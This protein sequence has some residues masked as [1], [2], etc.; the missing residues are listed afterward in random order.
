MGTVKCA[1]Q[2][3]RREEERQSIAAARLINDDGLAG[4]GLETQGEEKKLQG[5]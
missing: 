2:K 5:D 1:G 4:N 3:K